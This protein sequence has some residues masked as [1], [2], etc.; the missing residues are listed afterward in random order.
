[1]SEETLFRFEERMSREEIAEKLQ[2]ISENLRSG[3]PIVFESDGSVE[4]RPSAQSEFEIE[5]EEEG[6]GEKS[7]E[8]EIEW[9]EGDDSELEIR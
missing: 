9:K 8:L 5:V 2:T 1:M 4:L 6:R 3:E 7:L